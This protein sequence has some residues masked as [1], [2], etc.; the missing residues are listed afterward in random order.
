M[1]ATEPVRPAP[2]ARFVVRRPVAAFLVIGLPLA[3]GVMGLP[4]LARYGLIPGRSQLE[5]NAAEV[6]AVVRGAANSVLLAAVT[7][8]FFNRSN[9]ADGLAADILTGTQ[10]QE[11]ALLTA[12]LLTAVLVMVLARRHRLSRTYRQCL[13]AAEQQPVAPPDRADDLGTGR[14]ALGA[15]AHSTKAQPAP[16]AGRGSSVPPTS[17]S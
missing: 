7:H 10:R 1:S 17:P 16:N 9:N 5:M 2:R 11:A 13:D 12:L 6:G 8:T 4:L 15:H 14:P 3:N